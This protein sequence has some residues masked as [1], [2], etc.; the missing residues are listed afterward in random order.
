MDE[1]VK[2]RNECLAQTVIKGLQ[3]RNMSGYYAP[4]KEAALKQALELIPQGSS[5]A[6]GGCMSAHEIGLINALEAGNYNYIDRYKMEPQR[7]TYGCLQCRCFSFQCK[8][9]YR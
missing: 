1:N 8:C 4:S 3:S 6:M 9:P 5:I 2:K 7:R